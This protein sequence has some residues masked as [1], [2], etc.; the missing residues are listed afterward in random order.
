MILADSVQLFRPSRWS[1]IAFSDIDALTRS[2]DVE[3]PDAD[4]VTGV[5]KLQLGN[6]GRQVNRSDRWLKERE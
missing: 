3:S 4:N 6:V 1:R 2:M 5:A